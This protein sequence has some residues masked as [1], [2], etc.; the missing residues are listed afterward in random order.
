MPASHGH[1]ESSGDAGLA[2][3]DGAAGRLLQGVERR[4]ATPR[5]RH[6]HRRR[7]RRRGPRRPERTRAGTVPRRRLGRTGVEVSAIGLGGYH[8]G[9]ASDEAEAAR[10]VHRA[11]D[12]GI[13]F[14]DNCWDYNDGRERGADGQGAARTATASRP[15]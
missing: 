11:L 10:I 9:L 4:A 13:T 5:Q 3:N 2:G 6:G 7:I 8:I 14:M 15:S 1:A 12:G